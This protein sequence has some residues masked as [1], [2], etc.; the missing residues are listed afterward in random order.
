MEEG[1][2][3]VLGH[4]AF[5]GVV[6]GVVGGTGVELACGVEAVVSVPPACPACPSHPAMELAQ[7]GG[8][9]HQVRSAGGG[10]CR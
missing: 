5:G 2:P 9:G 1:L 6:V 8:G 7:G 10:G 3:L 4:G